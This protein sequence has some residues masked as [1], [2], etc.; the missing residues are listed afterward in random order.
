VGAAALVA[1]AALALW[2]IYDGAERQLGFGNDIAW[3]VFAGVVLLAHFVVGAAVRRWWVLVLP[4]A[5]VLAAVPAGYPDANRGEPFPIWLGLALF[6]APLG[7]AAI[8][9]GVAVGSRLRAS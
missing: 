2:W 8:A 4:V 5:G 1:Y 7:V 9:V 3:V 6:A